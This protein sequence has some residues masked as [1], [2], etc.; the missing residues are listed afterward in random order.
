MTLVAC[1][2]RGGNML[3]QPVYQIR[4]GTNP[5]TSNQNKKQP[6]KRIKRA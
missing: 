5:K 2:Y 3:E 1:N 4:N 6:N